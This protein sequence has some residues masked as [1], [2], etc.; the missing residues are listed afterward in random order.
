MSHRELFC[1]LASV[2]SL[3]GVVLAASPVAAAAPAPRKVLALSQLQPSNTPRSPGSP[4]DTINFYDVTKV[5]T[6]DANLF[7]SA[8]LFS[9]W[10]GFEAFD[11]EVNNIPN[12][13]PRGNREDASAMTFNSA[14][15]TLYAMAFDSGSAG[16]LDQVGDT[17]G[18]MD[19]YRVDYQ[20][21]LK[22]FVTNNRPKGTIYAPTELRISTS[23]EQVLSSIGSP[24]YDGLVDGVAHNVPHPAS[25]AGAAPR[26]FASQGQSRRSAKWGGLNRRDQLSTCVSTLSTPRRS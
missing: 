12:G 6:G 3:T 16:V 26:Q 13:M 11:G 4:E 2:A 1:G 7:Q 20:N 22:D 9:V 21:L 17:E 15:G 25:A 18:D 10:L 5:G 23:D 24:L 14:N 8:P 19:L